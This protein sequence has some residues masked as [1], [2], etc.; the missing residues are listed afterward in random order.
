VLDA[1]ARDRVAEDA[2]LRA[3]R[4]LGTS[5]G[6]CLALLTAAHEPLIDAEALTTSPY[7]AD[8]VWRGLSTR[9][10]REGLDGHV[11]LELLRTIW[12][13]ISPRGYLERLRNGDA[14]GLTRD[15][16]D[17][18]RWTSVRGRARVQELGIRT[19]RGPCG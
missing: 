1:R 15:T 2:G 13:P 7:F 19:S 3:D 6:S 11:E 4:L 10:G 14:A 5:L 18:F 12:Q 9:H 16:T 17:V 8:V